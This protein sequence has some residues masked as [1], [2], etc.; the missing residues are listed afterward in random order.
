MTHSYWLAL[1]YPACYCLMLAIGSMEWITMFFL[2]CLCDVPAVCCW[3]I[4]E[5]AEKSPQQ[6]NNQCSHKLVKVAHRCQTITFTTIAVTSCAMT[7]H[8]LAADGTCMFLTSGFAAAVSGNF[9]LSVALLFCSLIQLE[10]SLGNNSWIVFQRSHS[11]WNCF[12]QV[13][14]RAYQH[15]RQCR[16]H[17][18]STDCKQF[19]QKLPNIIVVWETMHTTDLVPM[20]FPEK[21][22]ICQF[23]CGYRMN[24]Q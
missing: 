1:H 11:L 12:V 19:L 15:F 13:P 22:G 5:T 6:Q 16:P 20:K 8:S 4:F 3:H 2:Q 14:Q 17:F 7:T 10:A 24:L 18:W 23:Y 21:W 9:F